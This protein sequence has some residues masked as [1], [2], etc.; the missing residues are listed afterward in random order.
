MK[1]TEQLKPNYSPVYAAL[2]PAFAKIFQKHGYA[3]AIHG[4]MARDFDVV[5]IPWG[6]KLSKPEVVIK[7]ITKEFAIDQIGE[8]SRRNHGRIAYTISI[9]HGE[10]ALDLSFLTNGK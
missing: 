10:C 3:L 1:S 4:S 2:Y 8:P 6:E 9:G 5:A 7:E